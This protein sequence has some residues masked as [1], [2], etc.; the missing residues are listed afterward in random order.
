M[1]GAR[2]RDEWKRERNG[3]SE[4]VSFQFVLEILKSVRWPDCRIL[5]LGNAYNFSP[6]SLTDNFH[7]LRWRA[8]WMVN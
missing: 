7:C 5:L 4:E 1:E 2:A 3:P 6:Y 8:L